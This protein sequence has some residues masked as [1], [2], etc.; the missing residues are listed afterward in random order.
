MGFSKQEYWHGLPLPPPGDLPDSGIEP[1]S[2][3]STS[4]AGEFF[5]TSATREAQYLANYLSVCRNFAF[6]FLTFLYFI[7][8]VGI[9]I[10]FTS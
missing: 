9:L 3:M 6:V 1:G 5:T 10:L 8:K 7:G 2:L 4:L